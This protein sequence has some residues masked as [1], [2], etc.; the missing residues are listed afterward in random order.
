MR[1]YGGLGNQCFQVFFA[2]CVL[3]SFNHADLKVYFSDNYRTKRKFVFGGLEG[4]NTSLTNLDKLILALRIPRILSYLFKRDIGRIYFLNYII[5]DGY[6]QNVEFY[7]EFRKDF[8]EEEI[9]FLRNF[10]CSEIV[11]NNNTLWHFRLMDFFENEVSEVSYLEELLK[12][13]PKLD[14]DVIS[15]RDILFLERAQRYSSF[16]DDLKYIDTAHYSDHQLLILMCSYRKIVTM[17]S[18]LAFWASVFSCAELGFFDANFRNSSELLAL[19][20]LL[21][22]TNRVDAI[23]Q[24]V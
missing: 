8:I 22:N 6:F 7:K 2:R 3:R 5:L 13:L 11:L 23:C 9:L 12:D 16:F 10:L 4:L 14:A 19:H 20:A 17:G 18:T 21:T 24:E 15:N 1:S